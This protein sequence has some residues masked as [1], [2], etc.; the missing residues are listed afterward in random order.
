MQELVGTEWTTLRIEPG[1]EPIIRYEAGR[2]SVT[3]TLRR[4]GPTGSSAFGVGV[5]SPQL[6]CDKPIPL[7]DDYMLPVADHIVAMLQNG[8]G[9]DRETL[10]AP[11]RLMAEIDRLLG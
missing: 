1:D 6:S 11:V 5:T 3:M 7:G 10:L 9:M 4:L 2:A 8:V